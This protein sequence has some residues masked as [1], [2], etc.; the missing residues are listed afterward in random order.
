M[1]RRPGNTVWH[2]GCQALWL[3]VGFL[4][5]G[6]VLLLY[7][8]FTWWLGEGDVAEINIGVRCNEPC[9]T[10]MPYFPLRGMALLDPTLFWYQVLFS[11]LFSTV[12]STSS[13]QAGLSADHC[14]CAA[15]NCHY[16]ATLWIFQTATKQRNV[17]SSIHSVWCSFAGCYFSYLG[18][19]N[20][21]TDAIDGG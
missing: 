7:I 11:N 5:E 2:R 17:C 12:Q 9:F 4:W 3:Y 8:R 19:V 16:N 14:S 13:V 21:N 18:R 20:K 6:S 10:F 1:P 15:W